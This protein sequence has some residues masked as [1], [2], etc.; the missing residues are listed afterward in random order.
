M[1]RQLCAVVAWWLVYLRKSLQSLCCTLYML[2]SII[3]ASCYCGVLVAFACYA[4]AWG[5]PEAGRANRVSR[6]L[7]T[8]EI[9]IETVGLLSVDK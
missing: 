8:D 2:L 7:G 1:L 6:R 5:A 9:E 4:H 3:V